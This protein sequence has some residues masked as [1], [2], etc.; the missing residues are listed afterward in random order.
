[1]SGSD[2]DW[3]API[4]GAKMGHKIMGQKIYPRCIMQM[5]G[6]STHA[7]SYILQYNNL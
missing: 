1:M 4:R 7:P 5:A 2:G 3:V 6:L